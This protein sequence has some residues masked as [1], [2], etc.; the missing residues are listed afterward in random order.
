MS[1]VTMNLMYGYVIDIPVG[2]E[3]EW[4]HAMLAEIGDDECFKCSC[5]YP[6]EE[7]IVGKGYIAVPA[8]EDHL[9]DDGPMFLDISDEVKQ[10]AE[11]MT[12]K[13][14]QHIPDGAELKAFTT[15]IYW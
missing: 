14:S 3:I 13:M 15:L 11:Y 4:E 7:V 9:L 1:Y 10:K 2:K 6:E 12:K 8:I 5:F